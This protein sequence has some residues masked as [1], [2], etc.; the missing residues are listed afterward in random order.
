MVCDVTCVHHEHH[1][2]Q[3][4]AEQSCHEERASDHGPALTDGSATFCHEQAETVTST[5]ADFRVPN[6]APVAVQL[7][8]ALAV[9]HP[10]V[11][12]CASGSLFSPPGIVIQSDTTAD[13]IVGSSPDTFQHFLRWSQAMYASRVSSS[14]LIVFIPSSGSFGGR[15]STR[16]GTGADNAKSAGHSDGGPGTAS[17]SAASATDNRSRAARTRGD[18]DV[19]FS[20]S[21]RNCVV[22]D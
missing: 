8:S 9:A 11:R 21:L 10:Q 7:P 6:A 14:R 13:L 15:C 4:A 16:R 3:A 12:F 19:L 20:G 2:V 18:G 1:G 22:A 17:T 5:S